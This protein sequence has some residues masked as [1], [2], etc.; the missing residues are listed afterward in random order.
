MI[1]MKG[2]SDSSNDMRL[3][4]GEFYGK[5]DGE[6]SGSNEE[7]SIQPISRTSNK[8]VGEKAILKRAVVKALS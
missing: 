2:I 6:M 3:K 4:A 1:T 7:W 8:T 5:I